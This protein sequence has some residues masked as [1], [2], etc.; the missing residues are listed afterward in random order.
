MALRR[1]LWGRGRRYRLHFS[2]LM[3]NPDLVFIGPRVVVFVD[4]DFWHGRTLVEEG[5]E[6]WAAVFRGQRK[7]WW[8]NKLSRTVERDREVTRTLESQG[9]RVIRLW[10]SQVLRDVQGSADLVDSQLP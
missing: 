8:L 10:E 4:G 7:T 1:E 2:G 5:R 9:W 3:G 6:A